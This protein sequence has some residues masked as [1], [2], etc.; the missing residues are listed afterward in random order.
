M[1]CFLNVGFDLCGMASSDGRIVS[2]GLLQRLQCSLGCEWTSVGS[3]N[4]K[5]REEYFQLEM[6]GSIGKEI[7]TTACLSHHKAN[8]GSLV[9]LCNFQASSLHG[10]A[11]IPLFGFVFSAQAKIGM[12][13][14]PV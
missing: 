5:E 7:N 10:P 13:L 4:L 1:L 3:C 14:N 8:T 9:I 2:K 11:V 12:L 6:Y